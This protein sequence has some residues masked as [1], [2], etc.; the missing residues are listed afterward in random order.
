MTS[1]HSGG[2]GGGDL[3][4]KLQEYAAKMRQE[5]DEAH[6]HKQLAEERLRLAQD[7]AKSTELSTTDLKEKLAEL[8]FKSGQK[9]LQKVEMLKEEVKHLTREVSDCGSKCWSNSCRSLDPL[10]LF[11]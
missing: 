2:A 1:R 6:R 3:E 9:A 5:R 11:Q 10:T 8:D 7:E 4:S